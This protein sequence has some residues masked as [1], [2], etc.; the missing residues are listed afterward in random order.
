MRSVNLWSKLFLAYDDEVEQEIEQI[1]STYRLPL[2][3]DGGPAHI[4]SHYEVR[5]DMGG[6]KESDKNEEGKV[7]RTDFRAF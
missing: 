3:A 2:N 7:N 4:P 6:L 1:K 5:I